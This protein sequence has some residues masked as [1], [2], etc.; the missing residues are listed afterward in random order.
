[1]KETK[2]LEH[3][4]DMNE[5]FELRKR[6]QE[7]DPGTSAPNLNE[8]IVA[9]AALK[10]PKRL[11]SFKMARFTMAAASLSVVGLAITSVSLLQPA[12]NE[13]L[14]SL[15]GA[16]QPGAM[17]MEASGDQKIAADNM[18]IWP[19]FSYNYV[20]G[21]LSSATGTGRVYQGRLVGDPIEIVTR[22]ARQFGVSGTP[23]RD[24]W[25]S[26]QYPSYSIQSENSSVGIFY[27]GTGSWYYSSWSDQNFGCI[28]PRVAEDP[29]Q[30]ED[31]E[32]TESFGCEVIAEP[33]ITSTDAEL[34]AKATEVFAALGFQV[35]P[36]NA[37]IYR[38]WGASI[39]FPNIQNGID[40]GMDY[41]IS[42]GYDEKINYVSGH[43][44]E[45]VDRGQFNTVSPLDA[46]KRIA[47]GRWYGGAP[48]SLYESFANATTAVSAVPTKEYDL[49]RQPEVEIVDI[50]VVRSEPSMLSVYDSQGNFWFVPGYILY[51]DQGW[52]DSIIALEDG[53]IELP[54]PYNFEIMPYIE[55]EPKG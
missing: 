22:L 10:S 47:D 20:A 29:E 19:N 8:G 28:E 4:Q 41:S 23:A 2:R 34:V 42:W 35:T 6:L 11:P 12:A 5:E 37:R 18:M 31:S 7:A 21:D 50:L 53:V 30:S 38:G 14:F 43:S 48:S 49:E 54:E 32:P 13:P 36:A 26:D 3:N 1:M 40:T 44:F 51:N 16:S 27:S 52:F 24:D 45:L 55:E 25:S 39:S 46:V 9:Q 15:A 33:V 17:S